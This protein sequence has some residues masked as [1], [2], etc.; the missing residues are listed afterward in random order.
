MKQRSH[1]EQE[2]Q[3]V[4]WM[5]R[6]YCRQKEGNRDLC[7]ECREL[8][9]YAHTRLARCPY[10]ERKGSCR[11]CLVHCYKPQMRERMRLVMRYAAPR[12]LLYRPW[13]AL[14]HLWRELRF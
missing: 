8:L 5:I 2:K 11:R 6:F 3:T 4:G 13:D 7:P 12:M 14:L 9:L 10:G 1:I